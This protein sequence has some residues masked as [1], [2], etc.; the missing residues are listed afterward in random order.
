ML[1]INISNLKLEISTLNILEKKYSH[2]ILQFKVI[3][4]KFLINIFFQIN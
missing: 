1:K 3:N 4:Y 2:L